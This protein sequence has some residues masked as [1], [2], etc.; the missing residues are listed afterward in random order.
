MLRHVT[1]YCDKAIKSGKSKSYFA[2]FFASKFVVVSI[3]YCIKES[4]CVRKKGSEQL[5]KIHIQFTACT[6]R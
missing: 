5:K 2:R 3:H 4:V 1:V 6:L